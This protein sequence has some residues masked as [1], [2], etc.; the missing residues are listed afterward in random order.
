MMSQDITYY[1]LFLRLLCRFDYTHSTFNGVCERLFY[2][3]MTPLFQRFYGKLF[4]RIWV[5]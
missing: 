4:V 3:H 5:G 2:E 1:Q